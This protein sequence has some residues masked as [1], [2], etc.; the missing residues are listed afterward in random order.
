M[1]NITSVNVAEAKAFGIISAEFFCNVEQTIRTKVLN[2]SEAD[3]AKEKARVTKRLSELYSVFPE[4]VN[5]TNKSI[6]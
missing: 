6:I 4:L 2:M 5:S 3:R 1:A